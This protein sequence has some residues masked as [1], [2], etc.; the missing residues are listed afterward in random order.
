MLPVAYNLG[1]VSDQVQKNYNTKEMYHEN[2]KK[3]YY[4]FK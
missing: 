4:L 2:Y 3:I 1:I